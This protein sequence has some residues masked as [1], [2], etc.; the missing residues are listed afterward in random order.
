[1]YLGT[2]ERSGQ[3]FKEIKLLLLLLYT[4]QLFFFFNI[5]KFRHFRPKFKIGIET[6]VYDIVFR[7]LLC[8]DNSLV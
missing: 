5:G 2:R 7:L 4:K 3:L 1:M 8:F 6:E